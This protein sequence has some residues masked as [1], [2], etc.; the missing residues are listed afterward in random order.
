MESKTPQF[1][2]LLEVQGKSRITLYAL[3]SAAPSSIDDV[4]AIVAD[5]ELNRNS[6]LFKDPEVV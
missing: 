6:P 5:I 4:N 2:A 1:D 3:E